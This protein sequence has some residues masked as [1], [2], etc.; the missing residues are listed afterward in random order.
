M[1][2]DSTLTKT[3]MF[4]VILLTNN[5]IL[6]IVILMS[7]LSVVASYL[8]PDTIMVN[9]SGTIKFRHLTTGITLY[10]N[11]SKIFVA[12]KPTL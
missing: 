3:P 12:I 4:F 8:S 9:P 7:I 10:T 11:L 6:A 5:G 1:L 2:P